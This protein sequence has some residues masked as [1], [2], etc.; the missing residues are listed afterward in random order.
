MAGGES[1]LNEEEKHRLVQ[2]VQ[3]Q[4]SGINALRQEI[5]V[6]L[7]KGGNILPP[8][9][10]PVGVAHHHPSIHD[11]LNNL[12][13]TYFTFYPKINKNAQQSMC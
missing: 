4:A 1:H 11:P 8:S 10:P 12:P 5:Q 9:Q 13:Y 2:I 7:C 3:I 6:L